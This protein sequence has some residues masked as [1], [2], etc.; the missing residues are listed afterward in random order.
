MIIGTHL[1]S[2]ILATELSQCNGEE[3]A[4]TASSQWGRKSDGSERLRAERGEGK[5]PALQQIRTGGRRRGAPSR[6]AGREGEGAPSWEGEAARAAEQRTA[7]RC[8][9]PRDGRRSSACGRRRGVAPARMGAELLGQQEWG[10]RE[11]FGCPHKFGVRSRGPA[12]VGFL[13]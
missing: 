10:P 9:G 5:E 7:R 12:G 4:T 11:R 3:R 1:S 2:S 13:T 6:V 8:S